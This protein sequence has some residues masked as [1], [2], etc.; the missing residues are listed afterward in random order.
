M[1]DIPYLLGKL[2]ESLL[3]VFGSLAYLDEGM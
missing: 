1:I 3:Q 2:V